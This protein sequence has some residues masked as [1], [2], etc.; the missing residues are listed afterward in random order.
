MGALCSHRRTLEAHKRSEG[1]HARWLVHTFGHISGS[2]SVQYATK[3]EVKVPVL[4]G[5]KKTL[6]V[7]I[8]QCSVEFSR[9]Y[10]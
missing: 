2:L 5:K 10:F 7:E 4:A 3:G 8:I 6:T 1:K 9:D